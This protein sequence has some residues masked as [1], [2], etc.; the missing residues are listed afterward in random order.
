MPCGAL[1]IVV[2]EQAVAAGDWL[3][4]EGLTTFDRYYVPSTFVRWNCRRLTYQTVNGTEML[5]RERDWGQMDL[6]KSE[7]EQGILHELKRRR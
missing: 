2:G 3:R 6:I 1:P 7:Q 5:I 4:Q